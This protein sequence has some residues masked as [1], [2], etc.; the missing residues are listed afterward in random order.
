A[1]LHDCDVCPIDLRDAAWRCYEN[2]CR[3]QKPLTLDLGGSGFAP[4]SVAFSPDGKTLAAASWLGAKDGGV[5]LWEAATGP[6]RATLR[7]PTG[8]VVSVAVSPDRKTLA[9]GS[10]D[11]TVRLWDGATGKEYAVLKGHEGG[12]YAVAFSPDGKTLAS[13][14]SGKTV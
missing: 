2:L 8:V 10:L 9:T 13:A 7:G 5:K 14:G 1:L 3:G 6:E 4:T 11:R 12:V